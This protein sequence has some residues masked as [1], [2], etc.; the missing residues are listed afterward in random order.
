MSLM[1]CLI[2][3]HFDELWGLSACGDTGNNNNVAHFLTCCNDKTLNCWDSLSRT[4]VWS[5]HFED[6]L[7]CVHVHPTRDEAAIGCTKNKWIVYDFG[8]R[9]TVHTQIE[10]KLII[11]LKF[12]FLLQTNNSPTNQKRHRANRSHSL[13]AQWQILGRWLAR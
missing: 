9:K 13:F 6:Q 8:E 4:L 12:S 5:A 10:G 1:K 11:S 3:A 7:H 2:A